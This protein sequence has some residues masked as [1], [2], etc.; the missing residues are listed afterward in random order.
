MKNLK[1]EAPWYQYGKKLNALFEH[2]PDIKVGEVEE[3]T[4]GLY[5]YGLNIEV[6]NHEKFLALD[7]LLTKEA[8]FGNVKLGIYLYDTENSEKPTEDRIKLYGTL[9]SGN[10]VIRDIQ[11]VP[12]FTGTQHAYVRFEP[13]VL[14]FFDDNLKDFYGLWSGLAQDIAEE[15]FSAETACVHFCTAPVEEKAN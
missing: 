1:L 14:Q 15:V 6:R 10:P 11:I 3:M 7:R 9:F 4:G 5:T 13:K 12:D 2:D 8:T